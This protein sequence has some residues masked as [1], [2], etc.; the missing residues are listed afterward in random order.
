[1]LDIL[2]DVEPCHPDFHN[3]I[4]RINGLLADGNFTTPGNLL[5]ESLLPANNGV[6]IYLGMILDEAL[7]ADEIYSRMNE[8]ALITSEQSF[9]Q[10]A[11]ALSQLVNHNLEAAHKSGNAA[12]NISRRAIVIRLIVLI[13]GTALAFGLGWFIARQ[14]N[15]G[16]QRVIQ[17]LVE[18]SQQVAVSSREVA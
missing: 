14:I 1:M 18:S 4:G 3:T 15:S 5:Q 6:M 13:T 9:S 17:G 12:R 10:A 7:K 11:G 16:I 2:S 8:N